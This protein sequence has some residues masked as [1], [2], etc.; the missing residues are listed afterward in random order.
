MIIGDI[1]N[2]ALALVIGLTVGALGS[3]LA[4]K[5]YVNNAWTAR[6]AKLLSTQKSEAATALQKATDRATKAE[7]A[8]NQLATELEI[9]SELNKNRL[10]DAYRSNTALATQLGGLRDPGRRPGGSCPNPAPTGS[11]TQ[12]AGEAG[13]ATLSAEATQFLLDFAYDADSA[14]EY[15]NT[16]YNWLQ[17]LKGQAAHVD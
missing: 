14:A 9:Q 10:N 6:T 13:G 4:V 1:R 5:R 8:Q 15:A 2:I 3:G 7:R 11:A 12:P 17:K 16:C